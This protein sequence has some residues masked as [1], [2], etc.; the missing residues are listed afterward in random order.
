MTP[1]TIIH[2]ERI[3]R[4]RLDSEFYS[5]ERLDVLEK[6]KKFD[7]SSLGDFCLVTSGSTPV[8]RNDDLHEGIIL[9]K[10]VNVQDGFINFSSE[11]YFIDEKI[12]SR[13][14]STRLQSCD[15]LVNIVGATLDV[16]GRVAI[17][18]PNF[19]KSNITQA[20]ALIRVNSEQ[21]NFLPE[22]VFAF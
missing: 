14:R 19:P 5:I 18:S 1:W 13:M 2:K 7:T 10:T 8:D 6:I 17:I 4:K 21:K 11:P 12:D 9:L 3:E 20:M 15:I 22:F 16:I